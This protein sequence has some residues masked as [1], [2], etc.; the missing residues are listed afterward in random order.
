MSIYPNLNNDPELLKIKTNVDEM[1]NSKNKTEKHDHKNILESFKIDI[2]YHE[3]NI[4]Q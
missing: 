1:K 2:E 4:N 3:K